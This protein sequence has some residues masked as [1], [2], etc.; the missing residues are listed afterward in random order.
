MRNSTFI[1]FT[2]ILFMFSCRNAQ[3]DPAAKAPNFEIKVKRF[4]SAFF[5]MDTLQTHGSMVKLLNEYPGFGVDFITRILMLKQIDDTMSIKAFYRTYYPIYKEVQKGNA[6]KTAKPELEAAFK[7]VHYYFPEY[8][9]TNQVIL[10][11]GP[12]ESYGNILTTNAIAVGLQMHMGAR[13]KWYY[14][15]RIQTIYPTYL[16][17]RYT[18]DYIALSCVQ[19]I[20][21]DIYLPSFQSQNFISNMIEAGKT[22][23]VINACFPNTTDSIRL[24]YTNEHCIQ[25]QSQESQIWAYILHEKLTYST[26]PNDIDHFLQD[27]PSSSLFGSAMP[28]NVGK[29]IGLKIVESWMQQKAQN[30]ISL[31]QMLNTPSDKIFETARYNP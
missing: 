25:I 1:L 21:N 4:D 20:I 7:R 30:G 31:A 16:S 19:N 10:F 3:L 14:D 27:A 29:Y 11:V 17:R 9:L 13:S 15:E 12:L 6:I 28:A 2:L 23:Y 5:S 26:N 22:Q 18:P 24:G 8:K